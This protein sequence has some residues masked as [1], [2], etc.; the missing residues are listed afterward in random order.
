[1][2]VCEPVAGAN[3]YDV[4]HAL[5]DPQSPLHARALQLLGLA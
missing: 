3:H 1:V 2:P 5:A 4:L